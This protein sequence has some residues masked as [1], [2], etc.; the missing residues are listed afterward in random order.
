MFIDPC[1]WL[2]SRYR[3]L[4]D[5]SPLRD[6]RMLL[7]KWL[8][9][10]LRP[11]NLLSLDSPSEPAWYLHFKRLVI[12]FKINYI[13]NPKYSFLSSKNLIKRQIFDLKTNYM[14]IT[15]VKIV[16]YLKYWEKNYRLIQWFV[17]A[18]QPQHQISS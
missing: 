6:D 11:S 15:H 14:I 13:S 12:N 10:K 5:E 2:P 16:N 18:V 7:L 17:L 3:Y 9:F 4:R 1:N 8:L